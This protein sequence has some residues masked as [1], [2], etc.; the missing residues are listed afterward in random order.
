MGIRWDTP[1]STAVPEMVSTYRARLHRA[2]FALALSYAPRIETWMKENAP[3]MD[4]T[5]NARQT[6]WAEVFDL[7]DVIVLSFG[8]GVS[9]GTFLELANQGRY[10]VITPALDYFGPRIWADAR[11]LL[12]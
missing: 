9:Y 4:R 10:A 5:G 2:L 8:Y 11:R 12:R 1:P 3:W 7:A 6:L